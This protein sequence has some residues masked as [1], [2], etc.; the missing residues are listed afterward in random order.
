MT[1]SENEAQ[2]PLFKQAEEVK[3]SPS[4][5]DLKVQVC[6]TPS[7]PASVEAASTKSYCV[8]DEY[9]LDVRS[10]GTQR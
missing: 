5:N 7:S 2:T 4:T 6:Q 9:P 8:T 10:T 1:K 3:K